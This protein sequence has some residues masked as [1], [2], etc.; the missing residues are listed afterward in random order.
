[1]NVKLM[2]LRVQLFTAMQ[3]LKGDEL[4]EFWQLIEEI[5]MC[6]PETVEVK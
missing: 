5:S 6:K 2:M 1:M 3:E 4:A